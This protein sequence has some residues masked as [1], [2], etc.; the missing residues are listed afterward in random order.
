M[1][2]GLAGQ[3]AVV[4]GAGRGI[5]AAIAQR[6]ASMGAITVISGRH[7]DQLRKT[8]EAISA[9]GG[10]CE[11]L[12]CDVS[13]L[14]SVEAFAKQVL[15]NFKQADVLVNNA[16]IGDF[17]GPLHKLPPEQWDAVLNTN[18]RGVYYCMRAFTPAMIE[19]KAGHH[20]HLIDCVQK[21]AAQR[22]C[23]LGLEMGIERLELFRCR[24]ASRIQH[25]RLCNLP[26]LNRYRSQPACRKG[27][28]QD[29]EAG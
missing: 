15:Q 18:L 4:T 17:G 22:R 26:R 28:Q 20:Q 29:A 5:G 1:N 23:L 11:A 9:R 7:L 8:A 12:A 10:R 19:R 21:C 24:R 13:D 14:K 2:S 6:L 25:P 16:G 3:V 27:S